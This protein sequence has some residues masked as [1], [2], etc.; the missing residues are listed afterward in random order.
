MVYQTPKDK[1]KIEQKQQITEFYIEA[2]ILYDRT[3]YTP[4]EIA[5]AVW[6]RSGRTLT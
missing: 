5:E 6:T 2:T 1:A 3:D 4:A